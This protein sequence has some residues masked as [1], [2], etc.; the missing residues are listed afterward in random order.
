MELYIS[1]IASNMNEAT[2]IE[3]RIVNEIELLISN[4]KKS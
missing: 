2:E 3:Q 4:V 1:I